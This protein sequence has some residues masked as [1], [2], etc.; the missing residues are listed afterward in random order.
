MTENTQPEFTIGQ[1][2]AL[3]PHLDLWMA[4]VRFGE[5]SSIE[6]GSSDADTGYGILANGRVYWL[7]ASDFRA[8]PPV[9]PPVEPRVLTISDAVKINLICEAA[10]QGKRVVW[11]PDEGETVF[12]GTARSLGQEDFGFAFGDDV[13]DLYLRVTG[14][15]GR[16]FALAVTDLMAWMVG[17]AVSFQER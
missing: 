14:D 11:T 12:K 6:A 3:A 17:G 7:D 4:G 10:M 13:R 9:E 8:L 16:E 5:I 15:S 1:R 2:V